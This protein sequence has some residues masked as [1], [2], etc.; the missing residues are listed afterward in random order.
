MNPSIGAISK[1]K[2]L[3]LLKLW[4]RRSSWLLRLCDLVASKFWSTR[5]KYEKR[6]SNILVKRKN[7]KG[8]RIKPGNF[9]FWRIPVRH[10]SYVPVRE[11]IPKRTYVRFLIK[12]VA[13]NRSYSTITQ[14]IWKRLYLTATWKSQVFS[15]HDWKQFTCLWRVYFFQISM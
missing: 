9:R 2:Y 14:P 5:H 13:I 15:C 8:Y 1:W 11:I 6:K 4:W 7:E 3:R 12:V 10:L